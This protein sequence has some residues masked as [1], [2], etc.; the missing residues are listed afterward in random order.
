[1]DTSIDRPQA[2]SRPLQTETI[3]RYSWRSI[4]DSNSTLCVE[5][6][7]TV[8]AYLRLLCVCLFVDIY[9]FIHISNYTY[10][11]ITLRIGAFAVGYP[12]V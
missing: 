5:R 6:D 10:I 2:R 9:M 4:G 8:K 11:H 12:L 3:Y 7:C 1:M